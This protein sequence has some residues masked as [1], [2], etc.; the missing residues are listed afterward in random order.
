MNSV[1]CQDGFMTIENFTTFLDVDKDL[2]LSSD[3]LNEDFD[4]DTKFIM[5]GKS[6]K[7]FYFLFPMF[8]FR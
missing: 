5:P 7:G 3:L 6:E 4:M 2:T 1:S 8:P